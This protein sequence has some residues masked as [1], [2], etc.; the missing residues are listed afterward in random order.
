[1]MIIKG[2]IFFL[3]SIIHGSIIAPVDLCQNS[4]DIIY[5]ID[6]R[7]TVIANVMQWAI[8]IGVIQIVSRA[9]ILY[10]TAAGTTSDLIG[11]I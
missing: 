11:I 7:Y 5:T 1:M 6:R 9:K 3:D 4:N 2:I 8:L 10:D